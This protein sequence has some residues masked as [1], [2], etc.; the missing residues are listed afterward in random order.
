M[1]LPCCQTHGKVQLA[2]S[3][4]PEEQLTAREPQELSPESTA[5]PLTHLISKTLGKAKPASFPNKLF[6]CLIAHRDLK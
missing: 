1:C 2:G 5:Q 4:T 3:E 6:Q